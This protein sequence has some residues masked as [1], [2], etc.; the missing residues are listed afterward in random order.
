MSKTEQGP[1]LAQ[2]DGLRGLAAVLVVAFHFTARYQDKFGFVST[3]LR[4]SMSA[5]S[6][7][8]CS[9]SSAAS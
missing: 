9:S 6:A 3:P 1:R 2:I 4:A 8:S 7:C 5:C